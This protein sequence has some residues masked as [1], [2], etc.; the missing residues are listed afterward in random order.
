MF[1]AACSRSVPQAAAP[2]LRAL[3][4]ARARACTTSSPQDTASAGAFI[5]AASLQAFETAA[6]L[7]AAAED[8]ERARALGARIDELTAAE[9]GGL[10]TI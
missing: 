1:L 4:V 9:A 6:G 5:T 10:S 8:V 3:H 2:V 7:A